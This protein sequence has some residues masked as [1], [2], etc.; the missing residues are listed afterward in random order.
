MIDTIIFDFGDV[1]INLDK[2]G[3][4]ARTKTML[5]FD[6][7]TEAQNPLYKHIFNINDKYEKGLISTD[8]FLSFYEDLKE[9]ITKEDVKNVWN[10]LLLDF[11]E[12]RLDF[13][14]G[15]KSEN[16][17]KLILLSNT[18]DLHI[19]WIKDNI[20]FYNEFKCCFDAFYLSHEI[21]LRKPNQD[22]FKYVL[23]N[24][25]LNPNNT[26]FIDDT[27]EN[28]NAASQLG[29]HVWNNNPE[30]QDIVD[31]FEIKKH[32]FE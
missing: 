19:S 23:E 12:Y 2:K 29:I 3:T 9:G 26:L 22:I 16:R 17:F 13:I 6:I 7:I 30:T 4:I 20:S 10:S 21:H 31:L 32:L 24:N 25:D 18:N 27:I 15:L 28:T 14:K 5:G 1:F 11:P 8:H